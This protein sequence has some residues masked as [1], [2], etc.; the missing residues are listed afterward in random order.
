[1]KLPWKTRSHKA[2]FSRGTTRRGVKQPIIN[3]MKT[4]LFKYIENTNTKKW[5]FSDINSD[6]FHISVQNMD[7]GYSLE[8]HR[9]GGSSE[10]PQSVFL[11][12]WDKNNVYPCK[13]QFNYMYIKIVFKEVKII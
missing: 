1:M 8:P 13:L 6:I 2:G 5:K 3:I 12:K 7:C 4:R 11:S 9:Q 10:Y